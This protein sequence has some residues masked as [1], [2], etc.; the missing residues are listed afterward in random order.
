MLRR[1]YSWLPYDDFKLFSLVVKASTSR[2]D[3][4]G[5]ESRLRH[6]DFSGSTHAKTGWRG[7]S[8]P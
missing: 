6:G 5:F 8:I 3:D 7:V 1:Q 2:A 4:P